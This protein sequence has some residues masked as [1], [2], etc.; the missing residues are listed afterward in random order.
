MS[1]QTD[2]WTPI[3]AP[4]VV[5]KVQSWAIEEPTPQE[6]TP[7]EPTPQGNLYDPSSQTGQGSEVVPVKDGFATWNTLTPLVNFKAPGSLSSEP[8]GIQDVSVLLTLSCFNSICKHFYAEVLA[9]H[10]RQPH[11][12]GAGRT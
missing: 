2:L 12:A 6:P 7:Q 9:H 11:K 3:E 10:H 4:V 1:E 8:N 5:V